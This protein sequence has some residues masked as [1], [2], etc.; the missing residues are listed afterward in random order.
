MDIPDQEIWH[1]GYPRPRNMTQWI[2][3]TKKYD[4]MDTLDQEIWHN[5][6]PRPRNMTQWISQTKKYDTMNT[7]DQEIWHIMDTPDQEIWHFTSKCHP[8]LGVAWDTPWWPQA[9]TVKLLHSSFVKV[10]LLKLI[11][12]QMCMLSHL[13]CM[14]MVFTV[15]YSVFAFLKKN[16][17]ISVKW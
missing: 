11:Y 15:E 5:G 12:L 14:F 3:Q 16:C 4:T 6:Y 13:C 8:D 10:N 17:A 1:N 7:Q 2:S 9:K